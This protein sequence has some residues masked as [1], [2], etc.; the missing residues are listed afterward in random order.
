MASLCRRTRRVAPA[1][2]T[3][4]SFACR[5]AAVTAAPLRGGASRR[6][7]RTREA[8]R[9]AS[10]RKLESHEFGQRPVVSKYSIGAGVK[11]TISINSPI[12]ARINRVRSIRTSSFNVG[13]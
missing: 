7:L 10:G 1:H 8:R 3:L 5:S 2:D 11:H 6:D 9:R 4:I 12:T 13:G